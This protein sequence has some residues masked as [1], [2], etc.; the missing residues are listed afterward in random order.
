MKP[1]LL[2]TKNILFD[3]PI[4]QQVQ[5]LNKEIISSSKLLDRLN[6]KDEQPDWLQLFSTAIISE[7]IGK[8]EL[9][10]ILLYL[11]KYDIPT[12]RLVETLPKAEEKEKWKQS[13]VHAWLV[14]SCSK[15]ELRETLDDVLLKTNDP[16]EP[17]EIL[18]INP[19]RVHSIKFSMNEKKV[20]ALMIEHPNEAVSRETFCKK[21]WGESTPSTKSQLSYL[22]SQIKMKLATISSQTSIIDTVWGSGYLI[23]DYACPI[24]S[25]YLNSSNEA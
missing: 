15:E 10:K 18:M 17:K 2:L 7:T 21:I 9:L 20:L 12:V 25:S 14:N 13:G 3:M 4:Q 6:N 16:S 5:K 24:I 8:L 23:K 22:M 19:L 11:K 1:I